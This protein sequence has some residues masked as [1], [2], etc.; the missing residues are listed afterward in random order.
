MSAPIEQDRER[1]E[2]LVEYLADFTS[3]K[4]LTKVDCVLEDLESVRADERARIVRALRERARSIPAH[5]R[6]DVDLVW[7]KASREIEDGTL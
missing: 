6:G 5:T 7:L 1:A 2:S 3:G 4:G